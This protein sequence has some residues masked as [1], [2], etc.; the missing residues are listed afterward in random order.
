MPSES[1]SNQ[2]SSMASTEP[3]SMP[4]E[5]PS[6]LSSRPSKSS[7]SSSI[8]LPNETV[9]IYGSLSFSVDICSF[10]EDELAAFVEANV[11]TIEDLAC[12]THSN[13]QDSVSVCTAEIVSICGSQQ[14]QLLQSSRELQAYAW[15]L[16]YRVIITFTCAV[17]GCNSPA[18]IAAVSSISEA[19][20]ANIGNSMENGSF[21]T[22]LS[23]NIVPTS[24]L[25][26]SIMNCLTV[27]SNFGDEDPETEVYVDKG[28]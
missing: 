21:L 23:T 22:V 24:G 10:S 8:F 3:S 17:E 14:G 20:S 15:Q 27:W 6:S 9:T 1:P 12:A 19:I 13:S 5:S 18:D 16:E 2:P 4:S 26:A 28:T 25:D 7:Q 11:A